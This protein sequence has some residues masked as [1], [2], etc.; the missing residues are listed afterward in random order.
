MNLAISVTTIRLILGIIAAILVG[1]N[2]PL[3]VAILITLAFLLDIADGKIARARGETTTFGVYYD[4]LADKIIIVGLL[5][6]LGYEDYISFYIGLLL[7]IREYMIDSIRTVAISQGTV[8]SANW[9]S[10]LKG[11]MFMLAI[12]GI[13]WAQVINTPELTYASN[14]LGWIAL[15][16]SYV[17]LL[18]FFVKNSQLIRQAALLKK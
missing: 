18:V 13:V 6:V 2:H 10:K 17:T 1:T 9:Q 8:I 15:V 5:L 4:I 14:I 3:L 7:F 12:L 11:A 16:F